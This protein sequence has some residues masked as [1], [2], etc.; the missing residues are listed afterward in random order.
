MQKHR[1]TAKNK[2]H[3]AAYR[4]RVGTFIK[5][6]INESSSNPN[7]NNSGDFINQ[8]D[9][10]SDS[11]TSYDP[12]NSAK[13]GPSHRYDFKNP[14]DVP[15][16]TIENMDIGETTTLAKDVP[17]YPKGDYEVILRPKNGSQPDISQN[18]IRFN[19]NF[20]GFKLSK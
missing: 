10:V 16:I 2:E 4:Q 14:I 13:K 15:N 17:D 5:K 1:Q 18:H 3:N 11:P 6:M 19:S 7:F 12:L 9:L 8:V 20:A